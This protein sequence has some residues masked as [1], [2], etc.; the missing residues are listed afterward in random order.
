MTN[1]QNI[2]TRFY[3]DRTVAH[4]TFII[5]GVLLVLMASF[6]LLDGLSLR[7]VIF[8]L[9]SGAILAPFWFGFTQ[10]TYVEISD[11][12]LRVSRMFFRGK[13]TSLSNAISIHQRPIYGGLFAEVYLKVRKPDGTFREQ[14]LI[15]KPGLKEGD[16][17][18]LLEMIRS[19]NPNIEVDQDLL[20]KT[21]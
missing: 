19:I 18:K 4:G 15:N 17:K 21:P 14:G 3:L 8:L 12:K 9:V 10:G 2:K 5:L 20:H 11:K 7:P 6:S 13:Y 1:I 16:M